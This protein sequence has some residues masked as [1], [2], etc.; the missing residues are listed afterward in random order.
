[1]NATDTSLL[2][3]LAGVI[4]PLLVG[5]VTKA[6]ASSGIK[7]IVNAALTALGGLVATV[8]PGDDFQWHPFLAAWLTA[9]LTSVG[10]YYGLLKPTGVAPAVQH[11][12]AEVGIGGRA[13]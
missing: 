12:T 11:A 6:N 4:I 7:A 1:M 10:T 9:W 3:A 2:A 5:I 8:L 13:A